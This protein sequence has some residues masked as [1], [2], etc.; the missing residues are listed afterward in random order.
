MRRPNCGC[1]KNTQILFY[2]LHFRNCCKLLRLLKFERQHFACQFLRPERVK[3]HAASTLQNAAVDFRERRPSKQ[4]QRN[5]DLVSQN[6]EGTFH[7]WL[8]P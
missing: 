8:A 7:A 5:V 1:R 2:F 3:S 4:G 6:F